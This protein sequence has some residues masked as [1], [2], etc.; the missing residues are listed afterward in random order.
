[1][2][3]ETKGARQH[4]GFTVD[5]GNPI[6]KVQVTNGCR[7]YQVDLRRSASGKP[8]RKNFTTAQKACAFASR[9]MTRIFEKSDK[10]LGPIDQQREAQEILNPYQAS[11][12]E[13]ARFFAEQHRPVEKERRL[14]ILAARFIDEKQELADREQLQASSLVD[15][16]HFLKRFVREFGSCAADAVTAGEID[17]FLDSVKGDA[18]RRSHRLYISSFFN[19]AVE[20]DL[21]EANPVRKTRRVQPKRQSP[22]IYQPQDVQQLMDA[23]EPDLVPFLALSFFCG[24]RSTEILQLKWDDVDFNLERIHINADISFTGEERSLRLEPNLAQFLAPFRGKPNEAVVPHHQRSLQRWCKKLHE[25]LDIKA[26]YQGARHT[27]TAYHLALHPLKET[28][29]ETGC[30][31]SATLFKYYQGI[32]SSRSAP[33]EAY[34]AVAPADQEQIIPL[35]KEAA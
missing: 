8:V 23:A 17:H 14:E 12:S 33:A 4:R 26:L 19:W 30:S 29:D 11:I 28:M 2:S 24:A 13:A 18:N 10:P 15:I 31:K 6:R 32:G 20:K 16:R 9:A 7:Y 34:F 3:Q 21:I 22:G 27:F 35:R 1:M 5:N 25:E